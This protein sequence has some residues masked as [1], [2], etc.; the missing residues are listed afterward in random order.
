MNFPMVDMK[1]HGLTFIASSICVLLILFD[2]SLP[3]EI[4]DAA[5]TDV[6]KLFMAIILI[7]MFSTTHPIAG[8]L[9]IIAF[10]KLSIIETQGS[11]TVRFNEDK[12]P[13]STVPK[14][15]ADDMVQ[16]NN[17]NEVVS[18]D[19]GGTLEE[20]MVTKMA[21][22]KKASGGSSTET[23]VPVLDTSINAT[24]IDSA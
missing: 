5:K 4:L 8:V 6:G 11:K 21:P 24:S 14:R 19:V 10:W 15:G 20:E 2:T 1:K 7:G 16:Y 12:R 18:G 17:T 3:R 23:Y 22:L 9:A 13:A